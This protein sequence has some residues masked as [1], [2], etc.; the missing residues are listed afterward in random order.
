M[1]NVKYANQVVG[2]R[3]RVDKQDS[4]KTKKTDIDSAKTKKETSLIKE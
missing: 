2:V 1:I 3:D 4:L